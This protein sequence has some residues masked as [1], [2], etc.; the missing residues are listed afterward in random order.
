MTPHSPWGNSSVRSFTPPATLFVVCIGSLWGLYWMPLR[1]LEALAAAGPWTTLVVVG[2]GCLCLAP[3]AW[4]GRNR[5]K[6][7][8]NRALASIALGGASFVLYSDGLLYGQV[9]VVILLFYLT[10]VWST[11]IVRFWL[12]W[13][14]SAWRYAAIGSGLLGI[15][16][17]MKDSHPGGLPLPRSLGDLFGLASGLLWS[18]A[19]TGMYVHS[20]TRPAETNFIF[21][22][23]GV[24]MAAVLALTLAPP[25]PFPGLLVLPG[26]AAWILLIGCLW[27]ALSLTAFMWATRI[28]E[29]ARIGMLLMSEV[30]VG[31]ASA[32]LVADEPFTLTM[33]FGA[34][35]VIAAGFLESV[36]AVL[37]STNNRHLRGG[38]PDGQVTHKRTRTF[39]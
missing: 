8:N 3:F 32:A 11:L 29:P 2:L 33:L 39:F 28:L 10:P 30:I 36:P 23:G 21:C 14:V 18:V 19:S 31:A 24:V 5:L 37:N 38:P 4:K 25:P 12:K 17:V 20:R 34:V 26:A 6:T 16:L 9:A 15:I 1:R 27:W 7:A 22:F 13:P 35:L